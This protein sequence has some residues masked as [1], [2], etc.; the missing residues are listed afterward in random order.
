MPYN[1]TPSLAC[2]AKDRR[3]RPRF[4]RRQRGAPPPPAGTVR[5]MAKMAADVDASAQSFEKRGEEMMMMRA[6]RS[7]AA[8]AGRRR[9]EVAV[10][11]HAAAHKKKRAARFYDD[12]R[13]A[14]FIA[15]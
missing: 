3:A 5:S 11:R 9:C 12:A 6:A 15:H 2:S 10:M 8:P 14:Y 13:L 4:S 1:V 7:A